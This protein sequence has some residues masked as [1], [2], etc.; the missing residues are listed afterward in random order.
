MK[1]W[2]LILALALAPTAAVAGS[3]G[4]GEAIAVKDVTHT[5]PHRGTTLMKDATLTFDSVEE[6]ASIQNQLLV[7]S[8]HEVK[9]KNGKFVVVRYT[10]KNNARE[11]LD[12]YPLFFGGCSLQDDKGESFSISKASGQFAQAAKIDMQGKRMAAGEGTTSCIV[13]DVPEGSAP[14]SLKL[15]LIDATVSLAGGAPAR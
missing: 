10:V 6:H 11:M 14:A 8:A 3:Y 1:T 4:L 13:F 9:P 2:F 5:D 15:D 12:I 7:T